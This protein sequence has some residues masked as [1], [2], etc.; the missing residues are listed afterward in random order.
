VA[1][2]AGVAG[3]LGLLGL[4][5]D[6]IRGIQDVTRPWPTA[7]RTVV[8]TLSEGER[9]VVQRGA[10]TLAGRAGMAR[11]IRLSHA[12]R[13]RAPALCVP[14]VL[15]GDADD[16]R[17]P[18]VATR[19][20]DGQ[21]GSELLAS[22]EQAAALGAIAGAAAAAVARTSPEGL[23]L[24]RRW[25]DPMALSSAAGRWLRLVAAGLEVNESRATGP[26]EIPLDGAQALIERIPSLLEASPATV[27][28]GDLAPVNLVVRD[29]ALAGV[30]DLERMRLAPTALD[31]AWF[32]YLVQLHHPERQQ[33]VWLPFAA[34]RNLPDGSESTDVLDD[35]ATLA[36][37]ELAA[38]APTSPA[39]AM[40]TLRFVSLLT[41]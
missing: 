22:N 10:L 1:D 9:V 31:A 21:A 39:R 20:V 33:A 12:L 30:L 41:R 27:A 2:I 37:L 32:R 29:G 5:P 4:S 16:P 26:G 23:R 35:L 3:L 7:T 17:G 15:G 40:W 18:W 34:A 19:F 25:A 13:S 11:R 24:S 8:V 6:E 28:H 14:E 36:C 38:T